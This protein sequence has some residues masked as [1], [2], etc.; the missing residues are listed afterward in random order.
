L[1]REQIQ[2]ARKRVQLEETR[3]AELWS[4]PAELEEDKSREDEFTEFLQ[5]LFL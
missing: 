1:T 3:A 2:A 4:K 5:D